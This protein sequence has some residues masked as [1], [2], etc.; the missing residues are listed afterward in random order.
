MNIVNNISFGRRKTP[1]YIYHFTN[2]KSYQSILND[3]FIK[4]SPNDDYLKG[5]GIFA[6]ALQDFFKHWGL[7]KDWA[8]CKYDSETLRTSL[9]RKA[10]YWMYPVDN[11]NELVILKIPTDKLDKTKLKI[12]SQNRFFKFMKSEQVI[13]CAPCALREHLE[14]E[15]LA[16]ESRRF[17]N[18]GEA[19]EYIYQ[20]NIPINYVE[21]VG[22]T[23]DIYQLRQN[24]KTKISEAKSLSSEEI[25][26]EALKQV[27]KN[28]AEEKGL[29]LINKKF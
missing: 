26:L 17:N 25:T 18:R 5:K 24:L 22:Q 11:E 28:T 19:L 21:Q 16:N 6:V 1:R 13:N 3:G 4:A 29:F 2:Q 15:T 12:R 27:F 23:V 9:L 20:E 7:N 10:I 8:D 14:G